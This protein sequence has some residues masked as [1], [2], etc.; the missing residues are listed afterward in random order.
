LS[1][2]GLRLYG[3]LAWPWIVVFV[4]TGSGGVGSFLTKLTKMKDHHEV[5]GWFATEVLLSGLAAHLL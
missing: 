1:I 3:I 2:R 5:E 4:K